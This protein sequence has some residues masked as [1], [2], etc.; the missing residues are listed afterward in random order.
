MDFHILGPIEAIEG[1]RPLA[2]GGAKQRAL[3]GMLLLHANEVVSTDRL[4]D[5]LWA[6]DRRE[7]ALKSLQVAVSRLRKALDAGR[8]AGAEGA[9]IVT[10]SPGYELQVDP[11]RL[12]VTRFDAFV[13]HGRGALAAADAQS[14]RQQFDAALRLWR[15]PP[16][17]DLA[18]ESFA[19]SEIARLEELRLGALE[20]R[21]QADLA[22][23]HHDQIVGELEGLASEHPLRERLRGLLMLALYRSGRQ[24]DALEAYQAARKALVEELGIEPG[25]DLRDLH[26]A[27]LRQ[28]PGLDPATEPEAAV[29]SARSAFVG[30]DSELA[31]LVAGLDD[32]FAGR[33]RLFLLAGEPGI[34]KSRLAEELIGRAAGRGA[35]VLV[36]RCWEA[37]GAPAYWPWVQSLRAYVR[38]APPDVLRREL[39]PGAAD[40]AE[41]LPELR[42][43]FPDLPEPPSPVSEGG[44]FRLFE[45]ASSLLLS[46]TRDR[47][48][49]LVLD[50]LHAA[51]EPSLLL[52]RFVAREIG[53]SR[54]LVVC[55]YRDVDPTL[56]DPLS[57][58][59]A[60]LVREP[61]TAHIAL[62][63]LRE[64]DVAEYF[65]LSTGVEP[66]ARL[67]EA[68]HT[69]TEGNPL[70]MA[71]VVRLLAGEGHVADPGAHLRIPP[72]VRAVIGRRV[73]RLSERC[74]DLL[75]SASVMGREF[76][77]DAL[78][79]LSGLSPDELLD[80]LDEA[81]AER[82]LGAVPASPGRLRFGHALIRDTLYE[83]LTPARR[84]RLH[85]A[86]AAALEAVHAAELEPHLAEL[87]QHYFAAAPAGV[88]DQAIEYARRAGDRAASQL[89][90]EEAVRLYRMAIDALAIRGQVDEVARCEL[91]LALGEAQ[92]RAGDTTAAKEALLDAADI[93]RKLHLPEQ[94]GRA[95]LG[96][97]GRFVWPRATDERTIPLLEEALQLLEGDSA[98]RVGVLARLCGALRAEPWRHE[99]RAAISKE[100]VASARRLG[101]PA[102]LAY[103]LEGRWAVL[104]DPVPENPEER[105]RVGTEMAE[106]GHE[107]GD[108]ERAWSGHLAR[109]ILL[110]ELGD[111]RAADAELDKVVDLA[112]V[113][114]QPAQLQMTLGARAIFALLDGRLEAGEA[115][116]GESVRL[117]ERTWMRSLLN[118]RMELWM[119]RRHQGRLSEVKE[120]I[121]RCLVEFPERGP[122]CRCVLAHLNAELGDM[123]ETRRL[124]DALA[125][126]QFANV[127]PTS[128][129]LVNLG[130]LS[131]VAAMLNDA[132]HAEVLYELLLPAAACNAVDL[133]E[134]FTGA[135]ARNLG[136]LAAVMRRWAD[137]ERHFQAALE[138]NERFGA[139]PWVAYT[140]LGFSRMLLARNET[141]DRQQS[142]DLL[143][144]ARQSF[145]QLG[146]NSWA[147][148]S[149]DVMERGLG[150][151]GFG[152]PPTRADPRP[153]TR[154]STGRR[155]Y[156]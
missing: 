156:P 50:D 125:A 23:G 134:I 94:F 11:Q 15:G 155:A 115:L 18:Y 116:I 141:G 109:L 82:V 69:E 54:L 67:V 97:E 117:G 12:D 120:A 45:A 142:L 127:P 41:I 21:I 55:A 19:Q 118:A 25:R 111:R 60:E 130:L 106:L 150:S 153:P 98:L 147:L 136:V 52:L 47:P 58:A 129:R 135:V 100:A 64:R 119:L 48:L 32:A 152:V 114:R 144:H 132:D 78:G 56:R 14:A 104:F 143:R 6:G 40:L 108:K 121:E 105:L 51:D 75:V 93:A 133:P 63:G 57:S 84:M 38:E 107:A 72:G 101:D 110:M 102:T 112:E 62:T 22:L 13:A 7:D 8:T 5:E 49:V 103:A 43:R 1:D 33:G 76:G 28:D 74:R 70:F 83:E 138:M 34:G 113:L 81:M 86:A 2:L 131:D 95:A 154:R 85:Q 61:H 17:A 30:R 4:I 137:A 140:Q 92:G 31:E 80:V 88:A 42:Q 148:K 24:A 123:G 122:F 126:D 149:A 96:F 10:R 73:G 53:A 89:A 139:Q 66:A 27:I 151:P 124:F 35:R 44:R 65:E 91:L 16:L 9:M 37:G 79:R 68:I 146:M 128:D 36:G 29:E 145:E 87:A 20:Y 77:L 26:Q 46:A 59:L 3:L 39:G 99:E 90:H 71:E